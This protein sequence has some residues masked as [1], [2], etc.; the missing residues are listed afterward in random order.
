MKK[1]LVLFCFLFS[2]SV[3]AINDLTGKHIFCAKFIG[4]EITFFVFE[5]ISSNRLERYYLKGTR[6]NKFMKFPRKSYYETDF[7]NIYLYAEI[8]GYRGNLYRKIDRKTL[9]VSNTDDD[10]IIFEGDQCVAN[11]TTEILNDLENLRMIFID[12]LTEDNKI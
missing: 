11:D 9:S 12:K 1:L 7:K 8:D 6:Q 3:F 4:S 10:N 2:S 5:F